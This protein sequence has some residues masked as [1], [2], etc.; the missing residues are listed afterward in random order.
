MVLLAKILS[1]VLGVTSE[2]IHAAR[3]RSSTREQAAS[4]SPESCT[5]RN[6]DPESGTNKP[7]PDGIID[8]TDE[9][10]GGDT[11]ETERSHEFDYV[12]G[13][14]QDEAVWELDEIADSVREPSHRYNAAEEIAA[15]ETEDV[16]L[17]KREALVRDLV[18]LAGPPPP[19]PMQ[20]LPCPVIIPQ[21]RPR[22]RERVFVRACAPV[23]ADSCVSEDVFQE[24]LEC[25]HRVN[26]VTPLQFLAQKRKEDICDY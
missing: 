12:N 11:A 19:Q 14:D 6:T 2:A 22:K 8:P 23:L 13:L 16:K 7:N 9:K 26:E 4:S 25:F 24:F 17:N 21:K 1:P 18:V 5:T 15:E 10:H 20:R 3:E